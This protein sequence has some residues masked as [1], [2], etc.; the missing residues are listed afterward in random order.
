MNGEATPDPEVLV[1]RPQPGADE[2]VTLL[3]A[4]GIAARALPLLDIEATAET[5]AART[6]VQRLDE[7]D[8]ILF[9]SP[10]A[11]RHG[12]ARIDVFWPQYPLRP[13]WLAVGARTRELLVEAGIEAQAPADDES[14]EGLLE[15]AAMRAPELRRVLVVRGEGG[16]DLIARTLEARGVRVEHLP[17][18]RRC[19]RAAALP[20]AAAIAALVASSGDVVDALLANDGLRLRGRP[21]IVPSERVAA[22][23]REA[24][25]EQVRVARGAGGEATLRA[26]LAIGIGA[27]RGADSAQ[28]D[29]GATA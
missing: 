5:A 12:I 10:A 7:F 13:L 20:A 17:V 19:A 24:G 2:T 11:V 22:R 25:F 28:D 26:L 23:A 6:L 1:L 18:Y 29:T 14:A 4:H 9:T 15:L 16:R 27:E 3:R 8:R 21:L